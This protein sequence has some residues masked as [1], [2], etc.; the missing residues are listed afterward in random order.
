MASLKKRKN[1]CLASF[2][3]LFDILGINEAEKLLDGDKE[4]NWLFKKI[5]EFIKLLERAC[6]K[7]KP[8][9][10][11]GNSET[12]LSSPRSR[13]SSRSADEMSASSHTPSGAKQ[14]KQSGKAGLGMLFGKQR[15]ASGAASAS[16]A[17]ASGVLGGL[18][19]SLAP[20]GEASPRGP[21]QGDRALRKTRSLP[22]MPRAKAKGFAA[23]PKPKVRAAAVKRMPS[24]E[25]QLSH[26]TVAALASGTQNDD[27]DDYWTD[28][29]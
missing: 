10:S 22:T 14:R 3:K 6:A 19:P 4:C 17:S 12:H 2:F 13:A 21:G 25:E 20:L 16:A 18:K 9:R 11:R 24:M 7:F 23:M 26:V 5:D 1:E 8:S 27:D 29:D 28:S 15:G